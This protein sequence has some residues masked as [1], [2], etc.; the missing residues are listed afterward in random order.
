MLVLRSLINQ[1]D[2]YPIKFDFTWKSRD[3]KIEL[4]WLIV[5]FFF[6]LYFSDFLMK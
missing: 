1:K 2:V 6:S 4:F 3:S 5:E